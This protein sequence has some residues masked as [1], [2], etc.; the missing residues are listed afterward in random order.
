MQVSP[1]HLEMKQ[2]IN[3][4]AADTSVFQ[5]CSSRK[6]HKENNMMTKVLLV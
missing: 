6:M 2:K 4:P 1:L 3:P 5:C